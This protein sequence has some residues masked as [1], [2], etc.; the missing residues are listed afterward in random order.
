VVRVGRG[1]TAH[2]PSLRVG[3]MSSA[4]HNV[5]TCHGD[6]QVWTRRSALLL[7]KHLPHRLEPMAGQGDGQ[8]GEPD[9]RPDVSS[10]HRGHDAS[11]GERRPTNAGDDAVRLPA[12]GKGSRFRRSGRRPP[13]P[14]G[15]GPAQVPVSVWTGTPPPVALQTPSKKMPFRSRPSW[16]KRVADM[17]AGSDTKLKPASSADHWIVAEHSL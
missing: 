6:T 9:V 7:G 5:G 13:P 1:A 4:T 16:A 11:D 8:E 3:I 14:S 12:A 10:G 17:L 15:R 2:H